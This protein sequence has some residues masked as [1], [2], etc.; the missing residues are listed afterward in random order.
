MLQKDQIDRGPLATMADWFAIG[1]VASIPWSTSATT[2]LIGLWLITF[3][4][5]LDYQAVR[6]EVLTAAGGLPVLMWLFGGAGMLWAHVAWA[7]RLAGFG[8]FHKLLAIPLLLVHFRRSDRGPWVLTGFLF[9]CTLLLATSYILALW[10]GLTWR[11]ARGQ[12][13]VPVKD[14][15]I[16]SEEFAICAFILLPIAFSILRARPCVSLGVLL[17]VAL[18]LVNFLYIATGRT[19]LVVTVVLLFVFAFTQ[20]NWKKGALILLAAMIAAVAIWETSAFLRSRI[21]VLPQEI[22]RYRSG[23]ERRGPVS[24]LSTGR[25]RSPSSSMR[26]LLGTVQALSENYSVNPRLGRWEHQ[27]PSRPIHITRH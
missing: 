8:G 18:F 1:A 26:P 15:I 24:D 5:T 2:I 16:Q 19:A 3:F 13:G 17:L 21:D 20:F 23:N 7:E 11:G 9:S 10:P 22:E 4:P 6:R 27:R 25:N 12:V 14:Y